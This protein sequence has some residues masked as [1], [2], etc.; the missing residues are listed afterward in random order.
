MHVTISVIL[1]TTA[2]KVHGNVLVVTVDIVDAVAVDADAG[3]RD[4]AVDANGSTA[5]DIV[6]GSVIPLEAAP[7]NI[8]CCT[9]ADNGACEDDDS[10]KDPKAPLGRDDV[11][12]LLLNVGN[13]DVDVADCWIVLVYDDV[14]AAA[15]RY[16]LLIHVISCCD[17]V[18]ST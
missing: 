6:L 1:L 17:A 16:V 12:I 5:F 2:L 9:V 7:L 11:N 15:K 18:V 13:E 4:D 10:G 8:C 3:K 14:S